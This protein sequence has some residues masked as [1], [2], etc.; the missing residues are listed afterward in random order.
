MSQKYYVS[1]KQRIVLKN[2]RKLPIPTYC[3][4]RFAAPNL[5]KKENSW[6]KKN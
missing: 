1:G 2:L 3:L 4:T 6:R 5:K